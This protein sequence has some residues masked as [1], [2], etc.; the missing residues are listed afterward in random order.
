MSKTKD[1]RAPD[2]ATWTVE[3]TNP[4]ASNAVVVFH[5]PSGATR[6]DRYAWYLAPPADARKV[7]ATLDKATI[8][9]RLTE[10]D[11]QRLFRT[12]FAISEERA[13]FRAL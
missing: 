3:I 4:G 2:G 8:L 5:H 7:T 12:S 10:R 6:N 11:L 1:F 13:T 9:E